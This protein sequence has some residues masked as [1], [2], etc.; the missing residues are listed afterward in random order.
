MSEDYYNN[1]Y[2]FSLFIMGEYGESGWVDKGQSFLRKRLH[3]VTQ[4]TMVLVILRKCM[5]TLKI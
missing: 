1:Y 5:P 4:D 3:Y 2:Y